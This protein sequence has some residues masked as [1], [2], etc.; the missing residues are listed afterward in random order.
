M[1]PSSP[2]RI[3]IVDD[4]PNIVMV[5][6]DALSQ[7]EPPVELLNA[8]NAEQAL[9]QTQAN[10][11]DLLITDYRMPGAHGLDLV[12]QMR[13][14]W[15]DLAAILVTAYNTEQLEQEATQI[16]V[17]RLIAKPF[18]LDDLRRT[19][20]EI[21][22]ELDR[23]RLTPKTGYTPLVLVIEDNSDFRTLVRRKL[24]SQGYRVLTAQDG[25]RGLQI[26]MNTNVDLVT[27]DLNMPH[28]GGIETLRLIRTMYVKVKVLI[29]S[30]A[31][32]EKARQE[33][34]SLGV[35]GIVTKPVNLKELM[36]I[37]ERALQSAKP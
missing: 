5:I 14:K 7:L 31:V 21:L 6:T 29:I 13:Q 22:K 8:A 26:M 12:D 27:L 19:V 32:D 10:K 17:E 3:L 15:P 20:T 24:I 9:A 2:K 18:A 34:H 35:N 1:T 11:I 16:G 28:R 25:V 30:A 23:V 4:E 36:G 33:A 37:V